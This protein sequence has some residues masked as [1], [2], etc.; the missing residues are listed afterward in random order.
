MIFT[1]HDREND[2]RDVLC[3]GASGYVLKSET[4]E[5]IIRGVEALARHT[6]FSQIMS[7]RRCSTVSASDP[8]WAITLAD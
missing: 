6:C 2:I 4:D 1:R 5:Q 7:W 8:Q 3:A